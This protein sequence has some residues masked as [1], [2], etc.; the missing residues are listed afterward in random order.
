MRRLLVDDLIA[1]CRSMLDEE[2]KANVTDEGDLL[3]ALNRAQD[4]AANLLARHYESPMLANTMV[5]LASGQQEYDIPRDA[6][7]QRL[8]K[9]EVF[10]TQV[11]YPVKRLDYRD[12]SLYETPTRVN[13]PY[14][15]VVIGDKFR[16]LPGPTASYSL[17][18]W[19]LRNPPALVKSQGRITLVN[20]A[21]GYL[22][23]DSLG[24]DISTDLSSLDS[25]VNIVDGTTGDIKCSLQVQQ[26][27]G[28][29]VKF[30]TV[31]DRT[32]VLDQSISA[33]IPSTVAPDDLICLSSGTC[34]PFFKKPF[35]NFLIQYALAE[36]QRKLG[37]PAELERAVLKDLEDQVERSW[38]GREQTLRVK[39]RNKSWSIPTRRYFNSN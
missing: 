21:Q 8:E 29:K 34:V 32:S 9:V 38:V 30:K 35:S 28:N 2:N 26:I 12:I 23:V 33:S 4:Y 1:D 19:Y 39:K 3:P 5:S 10:L 16:L 7:E 6:F 13:V 25:Y 20:Q 15:Y 24:S 18:L 36:I 14:Y 27:E 17:R 22:I 11:Y 31:P 37:G